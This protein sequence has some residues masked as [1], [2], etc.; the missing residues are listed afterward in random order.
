ME[1]LH[2][3]IDTNIQEPE[4]WPFQQQGRSFRV[5]VSRRFCVNNA[6]AVRETLLTGQGIGLYPFYVIEEDLRAGR[7]QI[8]LQEYEAIEYGIY[9]VYPH[10]R[11][12][13]A[14]ART[15]VNFLMDDFAG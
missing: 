8:L 15:F 6:L 5:K 10:N 7:L 4:H 9:A 13:A 12:L 1:A 3:V 11:H 14:K 2:C